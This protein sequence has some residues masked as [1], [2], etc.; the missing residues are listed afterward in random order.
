MLIE[1]FEQVS[2]LGIIAYLAR[3]EI[4]LASFVHS[5]ARSGLYQLVVM[6]MLNSFKLH[7]KGK[8]R[9]SHDIRPM[10]RAS[11]GW[12]LRWL[13]LESVLRVCR[14]IFHPAVVSLHIGL[15]DLFSLI[16]PLPHFIGI[17]IRCILAQI[18]FSQNIQASLWMLQGW[19]WRHIKCIQNFRHFSS[20]SYLLIQ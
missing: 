1:H 7:F 12:Q 20:S 8:F 16:Q 14:I 9:G 2:V 5:Y 15:V 3:L 19:S 6:T 13:W 17:R 18:L 4:K 11:C 10:S